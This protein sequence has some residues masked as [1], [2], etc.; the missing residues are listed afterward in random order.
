MWQKNPN[1]A[2]E[3]SFLLD[4]LYAIGCCI[5]DSSHTEQHLLIFHELLLPK[6]IIFSSLRLAFSNILRRLRFFMAQYVVYPLF[7]CLFLHYSSN[8]LR[9][10]AMWFYWKIIACKWRSGSKDWIIGSTDSNAGTPLLSCLLVN[11]AFFGHCWY[12]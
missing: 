1:R 2:T 4:L 11:K 9:K 3:R 6:W 10:W 5:E 12:F 8:S 7:S